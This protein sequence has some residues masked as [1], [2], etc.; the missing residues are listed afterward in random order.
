MQAI[1]EKVCRRA[2][3][4]STWAKQA[5]YGCLTF[6]FGVTVDLAIVRLGKALCEQDTYLVCAN[7]PC[8]MYLLRRQPASGELG[9]LGWWH[10]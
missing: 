9:C 1:T 3:H 2:S 6:Y 8:K 7:G 4:R 5:A 10:L